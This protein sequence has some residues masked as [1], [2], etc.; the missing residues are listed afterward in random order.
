MALAGLR[1]RWGQKGG[2]RAGTGVLCHLLMEIRTKWHTVTVES[3]TRGSCP[4]PGL[5]R[6]RW[7]AKTGTVQCLCLGFPSKGAVVSSSWQGRA[8]FLWD[9]SRLVL[10]FPQYLQAFSL[11]GR[12]PLW[13][14]HGRRVHLS[15]LGESH[16]QSI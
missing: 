13:L 9:R 4:W 10:P 3:V 16:A 11:P 1:G 14:P 15:L 6:D 5:G 7:G 8:V 12:I 2:H